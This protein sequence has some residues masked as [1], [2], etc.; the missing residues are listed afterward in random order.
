MNGREV[1]DLVPEKLMVVSSG[2][3]TGS[4]LSMLFRAL[5]ALESGQ[6]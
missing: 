4:G 5:R 1:R 3:K 6:Y 2:R